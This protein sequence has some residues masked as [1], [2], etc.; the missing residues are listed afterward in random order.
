MATLKHLPSGAVR[1]VPA[2]LVVG[3]APGSGLHL[4]DHRVS[5]QHATV[6][7]TGGGWEARDLGSRNGTFVNGGRLEAG[8]PVALGEGARLAFGVEGEVWELVENGPPAALAE[9]VS[10]GEIR[11]A[12]DGILALPNEA[13][14]AAE[15]FAKGRE[16]RLEMDGESRAL[17]DSEVITIR[18]EAWRVR[19]PEAVEGTVAVD[20]GPS[21]STVRIRFA[22]SRDEEHVQ[23]TLLHRGSE[24][25]LEAREHGYTLLTLARTRSADAELPGSE[26]GWVDRDRLLKMLGVDAN[27]LN[28]S[29]YRARGQLAAAGLE[30][31]AGI[32]EVRRGARRIGLD[33][34]RME[35][36]PL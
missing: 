23:I 16:W 3:R 19:V 36:V 14:P 22:V 11:T 18:G 15:V 5:G 29:I 25:V 17:A 13:D 28:V 33:P 9:H 12:T 35:I 27:S 8:Q 21:L 7:W 32:V 34:E 24:I 1:P 4:D 2:R 20:S 10:S 31:A 6:V 30:G 26:Q